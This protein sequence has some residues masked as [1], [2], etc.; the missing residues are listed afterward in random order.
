MKQTMSKRSDTVKQLDYFHKVFKY[1]DQI[2]I[3]RVV[4]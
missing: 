2:A 3:N 1:Y 4:K